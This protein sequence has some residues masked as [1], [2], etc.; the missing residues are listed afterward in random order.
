MASGGTV[1]N[2][3]AIKKF[4]GGGGVMQRDR[5]PALLE[6]GEFVIRK[7]MAKAIGG[8]ALGRMNATGQMP[9]GNVEINMIEPVLEVANP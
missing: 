5:I 7:P 9:A 1:G 6:P 3:G 2:K 8:P 4:A